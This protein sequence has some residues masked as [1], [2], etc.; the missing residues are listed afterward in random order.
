MSSPEIACLI[1]GDRRIEALD[2]ADH[3]RHA[4]AARGGDDVAPLLDR[5]GDRLFDQDVD[6]AR[7]AGERDLVMQMGRRGDGHGIDAFGDQLVEGLRRRGSRPVRSARARC[8]G[9]GSTMPTSVDVRQA[10]QHAGM[11][12]AHDAGADDAD[13][14]C[15]RASICAARPLANL[16]ELHIVEPLK[17]RR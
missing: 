8:S 3:Q 9:S 13:A 5:G 12:A 1:G 6:V 14:Q 2:M 10:G 7:D 17:F 11:V 15:A 4:G 16:F